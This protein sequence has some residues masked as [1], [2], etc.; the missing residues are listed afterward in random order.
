MMSTWFRA[1]LAGLLISTSAF[2]MADTYTVFTAD[3]DGTGSLR[4]AIGLA[5]THPGFDKIEFA[6]GTGPADINTSVTS[7][8]VVTESVSIDGATQPGF[9][10]EP[11]ISISGPTA[12][13]YLVPPADGSVVSSI[14]VRVTSATTFSPLLVASNYNVIDNCSVEGTP[15]DLPPPY[16]AIQL[17]GFGNTVSHC[18]V[19]NVFA[20]V[21]DSVPG[22]AIT[23]CAIGT[24]FDGVTSE[25]ILTSGIIVAP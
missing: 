25:P 6:I 14:D 19:G 9:S 15:G 13:L 2:A 4:E 18:R 12:G 10:G 22:N 7:P 1:A 11:L 17:A 20:G 23:G 24:D 3:N 21:Q 16:A 5:N 8:L